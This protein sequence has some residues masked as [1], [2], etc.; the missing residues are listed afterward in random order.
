[1]SSQFRGWRGG[2]LCVGAVIAAG[3]FGALPTTGAYAAPGYTYTALWEGSNNQSQGLDERYCPGTAINNRGD[4][5]FRTARVVSG[6]PFVEVSSIHVSWGGQSPQVVYEFATNN[7]SPAA[8]ALQCNERGLLG[9]NDSG[10]V[11]IPAKWVD[12]D[13]DGNTIA[14][15]DYGYVLV[16]PGVGPIRELRGLQN[17]SGRV[18]EALQMAGLSTDTAD[19]L[20]V[21]DGNTSLSSTLDT[22]SGRFSGLA[23][24][25]DAGQ[26]TF[27]GFLDYSNRTTSVFRATP[28]AALQTVAIGPESGTGYTDFYTPGINDRG[29]LSFSTNSNN[30]AGNPNP[31][32]LLVSPAGQLFPVARVEGE[33][34]SNFWQTRGGSSL[35]TSLNN[36]NRVS[37]VAQLDGGVFQAGSIF[38]GDGSGDT[39]RLA[40][41]GYDSG[42]VVLSDGRELE[43]D[44]SND[45]ADHGVN[46]SNDLGEIAAAALGNVYSD[47]G[48]YI[49]QRQVLLLARPAVGTEPGN[50]VLPSATDALPGRGWRLRPPVYLCASGCNRVW[51]RRIFFDPP[52]A[53]GYAFSA[54]ASA[55]GS[56]TSVLVPAALPGGDDAFTLAFGSTSVPLVAGQAFTFPAP[57]REFRISGIDPAEGLSPN[58]DAGAFVVGLTFTEDVTDEFSFTMVPDVIDTTDTDGDGVGDSLDNCP[59][60]PNPGQEDGDGDG[61]GDACDAGPTDTTPPVITAGLSGSLGN[62]G[63]Y[64]SNVTVSWSVVDGESAV[65]SQTGCDSVTV[66]TDTTGITFTCEASSTGGTGSQSVT[67][68]RDATA[69]VVAFGSSTPAANG[70]GWNRTD[71]S[72]NYTAS[73]ATSGIASATPASP[74]VVGGEGAGRTGSVTVFDNAGNGATASTPAVNI[75]RTVPS[76]NISTPSNGSSYLQGGQLLAGYG[77]TD[78]LSGVVSCV[79]PVAN[80]AA[81]STAQPGNFVFSVV[82]A[83]AAGNTASGQHGYTVT[84]VVRACSVDGDGDIDRT[85]IALIT[86]ARGQAASGPTDPRDPDRNNVINVLDARRCTLQCDRAACATN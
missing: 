22:Q 24:I 67:V 53:V 78:G 7:P 47:N 63:W 77:C 42:R 70:A 45:V 14:F 2:R 29:W 27:G 72:F 19:R 51:G 55:V 39:P 79:G 43:T 20:T 6:S 66:G 85:D 83:D 34:F 10:V 68:R 60:V 61:V 46:S 23:N 28:P 11:A 32:V 59:T 3:M 12:V 50:P 40:L 57:V 26:A 25:N 75:D 37:F 38:V 52:V 80:G 64:T 18:N 49:G 8:S 13:A 15:F 74:L 41:E 35:G 44:W 65:T 81:L 31:R 73:D 71:V 69:P 4:V 36:F 62:N 9:I 21:T 58:F 30:N 82:A 54:D 16:Q 17:S 1:M 5:V 84:A 86:A 33:E 56:F 48:D 76:V